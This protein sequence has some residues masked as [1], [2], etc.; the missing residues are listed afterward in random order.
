MDAN[1]KHKMEDI[2]NKEGDGH[3]KSNKIDM[4]DLLGFW[5][6]DFSFLNLIII[7]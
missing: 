1:D 2:K 6:Y 3:S 4:S 7:D 5:R